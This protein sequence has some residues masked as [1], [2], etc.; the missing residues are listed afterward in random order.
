MTQLVARIIL[1][2][3]ARI[4]AVRSWCMLTCTDLLDGT[5]SQPI[6]RA[7]RRSPAHP[8]CFRLR[9]STL[10]GPDHLS[11]K[12]SAANSVRCGFIALLQPLVSRSSVR[13]HGDRTLGLNCLSTRCYLKRFNALDWKVSR[14]VSQITQGH[15]LPWE[16]SDFGSYHIRL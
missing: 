16:T 9:V 14:F 8:P 5:A 2:R 7:V 6:M 12:T 10:L 1:V 13:L 3:Y 15:T 4:A 11:P